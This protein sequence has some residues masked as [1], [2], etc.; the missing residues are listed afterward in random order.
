M[1]RWPDY[2]SRRCRGRRRALSAPG[3]RTDVK[4]GCAGFIAH[5]VLPHVLCKYSE[6]RVAGLSRKMRDLCRLPPASD[7]YA[8]RAAAASSISARPS[9]PL[10]RCRVKAGQMMLAARHAQAEGLEPRRFIR[11]R[12]A[13]ITRRQFLFP[14]ARIQRLPRR[15]GD[16][17]SSHRPS[18]R[19]PRIYRQCH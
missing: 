11:R 9:W 15:D 3:R 7:C 2:L 1:A 12:V 19:R 18:R 17:A 6:S 14:G 13:P 16:V 5:D 4:T 10:R 8:T